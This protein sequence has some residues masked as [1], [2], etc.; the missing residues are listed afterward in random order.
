MKTRLEKFRPPENRAG[1]TLLELILA[2]ALTTLLLSGIYGAL[3]LYYRGVTTTRTNVER[4]QLARTVLRRVSDD[5]RSAVRYMPADTSGLS[6]AA[7]GGLADAAAALGAATG[8]SGSSGASGSGTSGSSG[9][10]SSGSSGSGSSSGGSSGTG[11][12]GSGSSSGSSSSG[13]SSG[14]SE[15]GETTDPGTAQTIPGVYGNL[16][17]LQIDICR[18]P[19]PD[20]IVANAN[21][22]TPTSEVRT[23]TYAMGQGADPNG[24]PALLRME[25]SRAVSLYGSTTGSTESGN[26]KVLAA[27]VA[28]VEFRYY[29]T[30]QQTWVESWDSTAMGS[31]PPAIDVRLVM[32]SPDQQAAADSSLDG[33][34]AADVAMSAPDSV[35]RLV[36]HLPAALA[37]SSSS[38]GSATTEDPAAAAS[39]GSTTPSTPTGGASAS[40]PSSG[41]S[42]SSSSSS[43]GSSG[44]SSGGTKGGGGGTKGGGGPNPGGSTGT[45][46]TG[47]PG[48]GTPPPTPPTPPADPMM[49]P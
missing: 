22:G 4:D 41:S 39:N 11:P 35:F 47:S 37:P 27:E 18:L 29:D 1:W 19:R 49:M 40:T 30:T 9:S 26:T 25:Q 8:T 33:A 38:S 36:I 32:R 20:E 31:V 28:S 10:S 2:L 21:N 43:G 17:W 42:S 48:G 24:L 3:H 15:S 44:S 14:S 13:S 45:G 46:G 7:S 6:G 5:L 16:N 23:V 34:L 12:T